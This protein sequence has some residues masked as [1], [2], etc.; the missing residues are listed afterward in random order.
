MSNKGTPRLV[1]ALSLL[2][3]AGVVMGAGTLY[4][5]QHVKSDTSHASPASSITLTAIQDTYVYE[6]L[7]ST[8]YD[9]TNEVHVG[10]STGSHSKARVSIA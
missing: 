10:G 9:A 6:G 5:Q 4:A 2:M 3:I 7:P 1:V 8:N